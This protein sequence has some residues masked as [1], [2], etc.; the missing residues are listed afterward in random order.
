M[1]NDDSLEILELEIA[2]MVRALRYRHSHQDK[3]QEMK[4]AGYLI[5][6][7]LSKK[8]PMSVKNIAEKLH[9]DISTVSRQAAILL[10]DDLLDK[11]PSETDRRSYLYAVNS[12]GWDVISH[13]RHSRQHRFSKM[14]DEWNDSEIDEFARLLNKFNRLME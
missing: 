3:N 13:A 12:R 2:M 4:R 11:N 9:L 1:A 7:V 5:L 10:N 14:I 8:G 6:L